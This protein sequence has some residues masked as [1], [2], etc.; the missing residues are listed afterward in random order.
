MAE[1]KIYQNGDYSLEL[2]DRYEVTHNSKST[3]MIVENS[4]NATLTLGYINE[5]GSFIE[6]PNGLLT[7]GAVVNHG[8]G[9]DFVVRVT[10]L[11]VQ[12]VTISVFKG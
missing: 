2:D 12:S 7:E 4:A 9:C 6:F 5:D 11:S 3:V 10:D 1:I 8:V